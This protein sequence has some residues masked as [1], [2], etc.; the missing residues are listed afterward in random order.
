MEKVLEDTTVIL[1]MAAFQIFAIGLIADLI[2]K[3]MK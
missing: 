3:R 2:E 1:V